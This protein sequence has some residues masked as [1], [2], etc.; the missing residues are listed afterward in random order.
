MVDIPKPPPIRGR[1]SSSSDSFPAVSPVDREAVLQRL[2]EMEQRLKSSIDEVV[3][4]QGKILGRLSDQHGDIEEHKDRLNEFGERLVDVERTIAEMRISVAEFKESRVVFS[5]MRNEFRQ[6]R[7]TLDQVVL[8]DLGQERLFGA[9]REEIAKKV[10]AATSEQGDEFLG[11]HKKARRETWLT[12][13]LVVLVT[14]A[15]AAYEAHQAANKTEPAQP[16]YPA[17]H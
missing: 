15:V 13:V 3:T 6:L 9:M 4:D 2:L 12:R 10:A 5:D 17:K 11:L 16:T 7:G 8:N 14:L 1:M